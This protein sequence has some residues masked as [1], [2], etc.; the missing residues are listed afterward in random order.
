[1]IFPVLTALVM[2]APQSPGP[3]LVS[4][5]PAGGTA[6]TELA[7]T[8]RGERLAEAAA[9]L[10]DG[11]GIE[12]VQLKTEA[13][14][15]CT[16]TLRLAADCLPGPRAMRVRNA[17]GLS[18][19]LLFHVGTLPSL[20]E[21][22]QGDAPQTIPLGT[23]VDG[24]L[25]DGEVDRYVVDVPA[26]TAVHVDVEAMR[27]GMAA[28]D[29][30]VVVS[31]PDGRELARADDSPLG[32]RDPWVC[33]RSTAAGPHTIELRGA[34]PGDGVASPYRLHVG[35][36]ARPCGV[37]P[38]GGQPGEEL[39]VRLLDA[40][41]SGPGIGG[42]VRLPDDGS[43][44]FAWYPRL[45]DGASP[46]PVWLKV[47]GP[48]NR[49]PRTDAGGAT[50]I[51]LPGSVHDVVAAGAP[52]PAYRWR[53]RKGEEVEFRVLARALHSALDP[54]LTL[55]SADGRFVAGNDDTT[56]FDSVLRYSPPADGEF[57]IEVRDLLRGGSPQHF[58]RLEAGPRER[59]QRLAMQVGR[60]GDASAAVPQ[61]G[62]GAIVLQRTGLDDKSVLALAD[63]PSG[64]S[65]TFGP[66]LPGSGTVPVLFAAAPDAALAAAQVRL[67][68]QVG[69]GAFDARLFRQSVPLVTGRNDLPLVQ[70]TQRAVPLVVTRPAPFAVTA[71]APAV[72]L[73]RGA[74]L[75]VPLAL[76][77][78]AGEGG[79]VRVRAA[80]LPP[81]L[82]AGQADF[83]RG[84]AAATLPLE[85]AANAPL[86]E[87]PCLLV[88]S[89]RR[90][91]L[92]VEQALPFVV[93]RVGEP[94]LDLGRATARTA[95]GQDATL[96]LP[97]T[98]KQPRRG[99]AKAV[100]LGLPRGVGSSEVELAVTATELVFPLHLAADAAVGRHRGLS[101]ELRVDDGSG[102]S[103]LHRFAAG[104]LRVDKAAPKAAKAPGGER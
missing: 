49:M 73:I 62:Y 100:L 77:R 11:P 86:G 42:R 68:L 57:T 84:V 13:N 41:G 96:R 59:P 78:P 15:R 39:D 87:F 23:T 70:A 2:L 90:D 17:A 38:C 8:V 58:F 47:G 67:G 93:V 48:A 10:L 97:V 31:G 21:E 80:W 44:L 27:L 52:P 99:P 20:R 79:R 72:P 55:R 56:G 71:T 104:E 37:L 40:D 81:G 82:T 88:A 92:T 94:W 69:D 26:A 101:V 35:T 45:P 64:V 32:G 19:P 98:D 53:G 102:R 18:N 25:R 50:W 89:T 103:V 30:R 60:R 91:N 14:D 75:P 33:F 9:V 36:F 5:L 6:G 65:A 51:D 46:T 34:V 61:G 16:A 63:L 85:A 7:V 83:D 1:M 12:V 66:L 28:L 95:Q 24:S 54:V 43:E 22:R 29:T 76:V 3:R 4:L 74:S